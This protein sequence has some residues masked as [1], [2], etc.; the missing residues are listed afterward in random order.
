MI[1]EPRCSVRHCIHL[2]GVK[3]LDAELGEASQV[4][5]CD[6]FPNGI[7]EEIAYGRDLHLTKH[8]GQDNDIVYEKDPNYA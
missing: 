3:E 1:S 8:P 7:P 5:Y 4:P 6:A 2:K